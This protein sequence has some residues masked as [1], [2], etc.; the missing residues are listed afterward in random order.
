MVTV[1]TGGCYPGGFEQVAPFKQE[2]GIFDL[3]P[4]EDK[5]S[6]MPVL[7]LRVERRR[8]S[9]S[10]LS[11]PTPFLSCAATIG[12][13][14]S[15]TAHFTSHQHELRENAE[16]R[17]AARE[18]TVQERAQGAAVT[19][20]SE[21]ALRD[22]AREEDQ[23]AGPWGFEKVRE[24]KE[25]GE[26][27]GKGAAGGEPKNKQAYVSK[28]PGFVHDE[29]ERDQNGTGGRMLRQGMAGVRDGLG[30]FEINVGDGEFHGFNGGGN[31]DGVDNSEVQLFQPLQHAAHEER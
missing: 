24:G 29:E 2:P 14:P 5:V 31:V 30:V 4:A 20:S 1:G 16:V 13:C 21:E 10:T 19:L 15:C 23:V 3:P 8:Q 11:K 17:R 7:R 27:H 22:A 9:N 26:G 25:E 28:G 6:R 18:K 12:R